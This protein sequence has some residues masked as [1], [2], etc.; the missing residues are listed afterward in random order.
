MKKTPTGSQAPMDELDSDADT[1]PNLANLQSPANLSLED[2]STQIRRG[3]APTHSTGVSGY[4]PYDTYPNSQST[5]T[6]GSNQ[7]LKRLSEWIRQKRQAEKI[8]AEREQ[9]EKDQQD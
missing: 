5:A 6:H 7:E 9:E 2:T 8:K 4:N 1:V 3:I